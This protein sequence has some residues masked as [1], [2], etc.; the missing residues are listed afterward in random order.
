M[1]ARAQEQ[2]ITPDLAHPRVH[3]SSKLHDELTLHTGLTQGTF[4]FVEL[5]IGRSV[6][7][8]RN[9]PVGAGYYAGIEL[10]P[11]RPEVM[12]VKAGVYMN[13]F[14]S[15]GLQL[16]A[17]T[18]PGGEGT[19]LRPEIGIGALKGKLTYGYNVGFASVEV[20]GVNTHMI[21]FTYDLRL[22]RLPGDEVR[23]AR[24]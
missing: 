21:G 10:R 9:V 19:V 22:L 11:D 4:G 1:G 20:P 14:V 16:I 5:G 12:G 6:Y 18:A 13:A 24:R 3:S 8:Q 2:T 17:Y 15:L 7:T 23:R